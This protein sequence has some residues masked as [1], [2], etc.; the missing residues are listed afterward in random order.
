MPQVILLKMKLNVCYN[1]KKQKLKIPY[2]A[3][4]QKKNIFLHERFE[5]K[6]L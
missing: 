4:K 1:G 6:Y 3:V 2:N 5:Y